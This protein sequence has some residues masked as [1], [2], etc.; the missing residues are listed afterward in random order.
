MVSSSKKLAKSKEFRQERRALSLSII[1]GMALAIVGIS[2]GIIG[3]SQIVLFDGF[4]TFL[5]IGLTWMAMRVSHL[6]EEGPTIRYP[7]GREAL[8]PLIIGIE[9]V[10]LLAT[11]AYASFNA[12]L[13]IIGGGTKVP[14]DWSF[15]YA[16]IALVIPAFIW[17]R[18]RRVARKSELVRAEATQWLAGA[19]LGLAI[20]FA[21]LA[22]RLMVVT[23]WAL[24]AKYVDPSLVI[25]AC[26]LF[27][28]PP[29]GMVRTTFIELIEGSPDGELQEAAQLALDHVAFQFALT[30][31]HMRMT[32][33]GRKFYVEIDF[34]VEPNW[35]V[36]QSDQV[37]HVLFRM[38]KTI[39]H[40]LWLT[41]EFTADRA[42]VD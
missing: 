27:V 26:C 16:V 12:V 28:I 30:D 17:W 10:A 1:M 41:V 2:I 25:G 42:L 36:A 31:R 24:G 35:T 39:P 32:K 29:A 11:C 9:G 33:I 22:A 5:G 4:Y 14:N 18:L 23:S 3:G 21:F 40:D 34:V 19:G 15:S 7:Y 13:S 6:V 38:L 37:R 8:V 20:L